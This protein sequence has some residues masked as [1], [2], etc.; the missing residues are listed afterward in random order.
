MGVGD[1]KNPLM[2]GSLVCAW[3]A[4]Q[5][6]SRRDSRVRSRGPGLPSFKGLEIRV[7]RAFGLGFRAPG[8][9]G[10]RTTPLERVEGEPMSVW[11]ISCTY[12]LIPGKP[13]SGLH[14]CPLQQVG[15]IFLIIRCRGLGLQKLLGFRSSPR[16]RIQG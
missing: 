6:E 15:S 12:A 16:F 4:R 14:F 3:P 2:E 11:A 9:T 1:T 10:F 13:H 7:Y 8:I 5:R